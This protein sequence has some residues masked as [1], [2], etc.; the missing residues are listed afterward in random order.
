[1]RHP[2]EEIISKIH[3]DS[4]LTVVENFIKIR[5]RIKEESGVD[6]LEKSP[7]ALA[8]L[9]VAAGIDFHAGIM[10]QSF[11]DLI[12]EIRASL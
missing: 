3:A 9:C 1:M 6:L 2:A 10:R 7:E 11:D 12:A 8:L 5:R 4:S